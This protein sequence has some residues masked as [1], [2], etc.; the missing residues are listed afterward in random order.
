MK[1]EVTEPD[2]IEE[3]LASED[4]RK[5]TNAEYESLLENNIW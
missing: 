1:V 5:A 4:W 2:S 3:A